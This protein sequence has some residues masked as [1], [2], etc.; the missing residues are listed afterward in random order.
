MT[1]YLSLKISLCIV[2]LPG[3]SFRG[4]GT[5]SCALSFLPLLICHCAYF[6]NDEAVASVGMWHCGGR[7]IVKLPSWVSVSVVTTINLTPS[8]HNHHGHHV[9]NWCTVSVSDV[10]W[11]HCGTDVHLCSLKSEMLLDWVTTH[12]TPWSSIHMRNNLLVLWGST[13]L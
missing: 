1:E 4:K 3:C 10:C 11:L 5:E 12:D 2:P 13:N 7:W 6:E 8:V 9:A